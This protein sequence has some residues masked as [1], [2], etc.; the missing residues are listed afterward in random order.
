MVRK[1]I[2]V[3][4]SKQG[5][6]KVLTIHVL[7]ALLHFLLAAV[8]AEGYFELHAL[9]LAA[10]ILLQ[11]TQTVGYVSGVTNNLLERWRWEKLTIGLFCCC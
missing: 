7:Q 2:K 11:I 10:A 6:S 9:A 3:S 4:T 5:H 8:A 1:I